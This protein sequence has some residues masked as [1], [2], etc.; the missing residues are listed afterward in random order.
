MFKSGVDLFALY[1]IVRRLATPFSDWQAFKVG[2]IDDKG[3]FLVDKNNRNEEQKKALT[4]LDI[5]VLNLK[6]VMQ[7]VP[8]GNSKLLTYAGALWLLKEAIVEEDGGAPGNFANTSTSN[9]AR[10]SQKEAGAFKKA[11]KILNRKPVV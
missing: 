8:G 3:N 5:F 10:S 6:K 7:K 1:T 11:K 4:Y 9:V 2:L